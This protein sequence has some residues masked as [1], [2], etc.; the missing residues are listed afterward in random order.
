MFN[1]AARIQAVPLFDDHVC[2]LIDDFLLQPEQW[3][4]RAVEFRGRFQPPQTNA[5]P[6]H[7]LR[8]PDSISDAFSRQL[9]PLFK[10]HFHLRR[11]QQSYCRL[12]MVSLPPSALTPAQRLCHRDRFA[13]Q[14]GE[15]ALAS[16]LYLFQ[17]PA[18][19]GT[20]FFR[21]RQGPEQTDRLLF[22]S[23]SLS[24]SAFDEKYAVA[25]GYMTEDN[26]YFERQAVVQARWN[27]LIVYSGMLFHSGDI[28][29]PEAM[30]DDPRAG[31]LTLN[32]FYTGRRALR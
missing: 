29:R 32:G 17:D 11:L 12:S 16:V 3:L 24:A 22:D 21:A 7:E 2:L 26:P 25:P 28:Q 15:L 1:P 23:N 20:A 5:Y 13:C 31:R 19:G 14:N 18:L 6:G 10:Q 27:R 4:E 30:C 8:L 9:L